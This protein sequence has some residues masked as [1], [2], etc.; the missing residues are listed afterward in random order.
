MSQSQPINPPLPPYTHPEDP[1]SRWTEQQRL[2][3][4]NPYRGGVS[5]GSYLTGLGVPSTQ[6]N[7][8]T[9]AQSSASVKGY[10]E[11]TT[12]NQTSKQQ[13]KLSVQSSE[14]FLSSIS[15]SPPRKPI[16]RSSKPTDFAGFLG[17]RG[18]N[19][20]SSLFGSRQIAKNRK[21]KP[22]QT[23]NLGSYRTSSFEKSLSD[24][25]F[26]NKQPSKFTKLFSQTLK[27]RRRKRK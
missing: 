10:S 22:R 18:S 20:K 16:A 11:P 26:S 19:K 9:A 1:R 25:A 17:L 27:K 5:I 24:F 13:E 3:W 6:E 21:K 14:R 12:Q 7:I 8:N 15:P 23:L 4:A 2:I